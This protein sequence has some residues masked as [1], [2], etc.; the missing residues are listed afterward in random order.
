VD[1]QGLGDFRLAKGKSNEAFTFHLSPRLGD[2]VPNIDL[3]NISTGVR[4]N[5]HDL[6][7]KVVCL[8]LWA[9]WC[10]PCQ[11]AMEK[12][13]QMASAHRV[14]WHNRVAIVPLSIDE[15][16]ATREA[17]SVGPGRS[18]LGRY[19]TGN[20]MGC[21]SDARLSSTIAVLLSAAGLTTCEIQMPHATDGGHRA[22]K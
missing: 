13:N 18:L 11:A 3:V 12:L 15:Q 21:T 5:L 20:W 7:G 14:A 4:S 17:T 8:E 6:R 16:P 2:V 9:R 19:L 22:W 1:E 10:G